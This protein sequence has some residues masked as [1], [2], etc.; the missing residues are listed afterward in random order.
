MGPALSLWGS[1]TRHCKDTS[2]PPTWILMVLLGQRY[3][4]CFPE[5]KT[6]LCTI[7]NVLLPRDPRVSRNT[8]RGASFSQHPRSREKPR[9]GERA[10]FALHPPSALPSP[11][12]AWINR[13]RPRSSRH[14]LPVAITSMGASARRNAPVLSSTNRDRLP[15]AAANN[16]RGVQMF[17]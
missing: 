5:K 11:L 15:A 7:I 17:I 8:Q 4:R 12:P 13:T 6:L 10:A 2:D 3:L 16:V 9:S 1:S 14:I